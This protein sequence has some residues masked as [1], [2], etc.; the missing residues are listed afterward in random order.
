MTYLLRG[1]PPDL[2]SAEKLSIT[3][4]L[5]ADLAPV[6]VTLPDGHLL[7]AAYSN[8][9]SEP[10]L[11]PSLLH[12]F[13]ASLIVDIFIVL[14]FLL[15]YL[16]HFFA[17]AY[18]YDREHHICE[19]IFSASIQFLDDFGVRS[20]KFADAICRLNNGKVGQFLN[21]IAAWWIQGVAGGIHEGF[22]EGILILRNGKTS[23][24]PAN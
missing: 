8:Q 9:S 13:F 11:E 14:R 18:K 15:P 17:Q 4:A 21:D 22:G 24:S 1:L 7:S 6:T 12:R 10:T 3:S 23:Q 5:P 16:R 20:L 2:D 19:R